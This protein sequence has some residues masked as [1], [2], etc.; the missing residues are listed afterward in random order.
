MKRSR[1]SQAEIEELERLVGDFPWSRVLAHFRAAASEYEWPHRTEGAI[2]AKAE[3]IAGSRIACGKWVRL[4]LIQQ[5]TGV[6]APAAMRWVHQGLLPALLEGHS[7]RGTY[8]VNRAG[9]RQFAQKHPHYFSGLSVSD[10]AALF[11]L[12]SPLVD[13]FAAM[14][15]Q[16]LVGQPRPVRCLETGEEYPSAAAAARAIYV[17]PSAVRAAIYKQTPAAG[18][19]WRYID[20]QQQQEA[21]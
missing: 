16:R 17:T 7:G 3:E 4:S 1:W 10:L 5:I 14:P 21:A 8:Y 2:R 6:T 9:L 18:K 11:D 12:N 13:R 20:D 19:H 15:R